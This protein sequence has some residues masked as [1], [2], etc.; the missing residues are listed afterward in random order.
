MEQADIDM[1]F[2]NARHT[3]AER[4]RR[5]ETNMQN[6][7]EYLGEENIRALADHFYDAME[8][9]QRHRPFERCILTI[10]PNL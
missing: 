6:L 8:T 7:Y 1:K 5:V 3:S 10:S 9:F 2:H 4:T